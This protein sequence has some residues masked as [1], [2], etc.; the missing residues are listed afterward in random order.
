MLFNSATSGL[1]VWLICEVVRKQSNTKLLND[2]AQINFLELMH[3][4]QR[5]VALHICWLVQ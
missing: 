5:F 4:T 3:H 2:L 1:K